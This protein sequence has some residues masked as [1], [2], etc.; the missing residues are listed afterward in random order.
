ME[1][2]YQNSAIDLVTRKRD[3]KNCENTIRMDAE[4]NNRVGWVNARCRGRSHQENNFS[5]SVQRVPSFSMKVRES[6]VGTSPRK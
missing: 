3:A 2:F 4:D 5:R 6:E 1:T